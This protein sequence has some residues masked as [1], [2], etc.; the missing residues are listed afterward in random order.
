VNGPRAGPTAAIP[1]RGHER[2]DTEKRAAPASASGVQ[3]RTADR[4]LG[5]AELLTEGRLALGPVLKAVEDAVAQLVVV[6]VPR[7]YPARFI[8]VP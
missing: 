4:G 7:R 6:H 8:R 5:R 2:T 1:G 3:S